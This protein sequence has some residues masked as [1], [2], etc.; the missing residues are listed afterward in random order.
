MIKI[1][2]SPLSES[3]GEKLSSNKEIIMDHSDI[4]LIR[5]AVK[6]PK[7]RQ[8]VL[9]NLGT[10]WSQTKEESEKQDL[11]NIINEIHV[12]QLLGELG[13]KSNLQVQTTPR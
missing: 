4:A 1:T 8:L 10:R 6:N 9:R 3:E 5:N 7:D 2:N 13:A 12:L 11:L